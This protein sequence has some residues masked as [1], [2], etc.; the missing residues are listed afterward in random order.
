MD[1]SNDDDQRKAGDIA[2][3]DV[4]WSASEGSNGISDSPSSAEE[5]PSLSS[6]SGNSETNEKDV[7]K[8]SVSDLVA[9]SKKAAAS[10]WT[11]LH[12]KVGNRHANV[13]GRQQGNPQ[14]YHSVV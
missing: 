11:L 9:K 3:E 5:S 1:P 14:S 8:S 10:L 13:I 4:G 7:H 6:Q 12:A 2:V